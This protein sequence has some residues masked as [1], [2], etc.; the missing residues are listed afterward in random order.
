MST[1]PVPTDPLLLAAVRGL[2]RASRLVESG[3]GDLSVADF[4]V[5][6]IIAMGDASPSRIADRLLLSRPTIS[7]TL[8]SLG[9]RGLIDRLS[10]PGDARAATLSLTQD[11]ADLL[12]RAERRMSRQLE[13]LSERTPDA[14]QVVAALAWLDAAMEAVVTDRLARAASA[15]TPT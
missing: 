9:K 4:R 8:D 6:S 11:G 2:V 3:T 12:G 5:L 7:S 10:V 1:E 15:A 13:L 14:G